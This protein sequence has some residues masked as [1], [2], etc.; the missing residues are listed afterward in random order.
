MLSGAIGHPL[1]LSIRGG[2]VVGV[3][4]LAAW[5]GWRL[6]MRGEGA[7][8]A[9]LRAIWLRRQCLRMLRVLRVE[10][11]WVGPVPRRGLLVSNH[12]G[13][14]DVLV[15]GGMT[16]ATFVAKSDVR[17]WP[18]FGGLVSMAGTIWVER[19]RRS[20]T[21]RTVDAMARVLGAGALVVVFPEG[22]SSDGVRVLPFK[23][24]LLEAACGAGEVW[25]THIRY[26][27]VDGEPLPEAAYWAEDT[28]G[29]HLVRLL[30]KRGIRAR[31]R[32]E[33]VE[34]SSEDR[35]ALA[36]QLHAVVER[37]GDGRCDCV[38]GSLGGPV[39]VPAVRG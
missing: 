28:F 15:L 3:L 27:G 37:L 13:Y 23:P 36:R 30:S 11:E 25:A 26:E 39:A 2:Q 35:K 7:S 17:L 32:C 19:T 8:G 22:T 29:P 14:L 18:V 31:V 16:P 20:A 5:E 12:L 4:L 21:G 34:V 6:G 24:P 1:R 9:A 33:R 10:V 38:V